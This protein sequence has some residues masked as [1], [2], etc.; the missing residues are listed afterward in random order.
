MANYQ[1]EITKFYQNILGRAPDPGGLKFYTDYAKG[2]GSLETIRSTLLTSPEAIARRHNQ[3][4]AS[5]PA[6]KPASSGSRNLGTRSQL[7]ALSSSFTEAAA[8]QAE[9]M[10]KFQEAQE[11]RMREFQQQTIAAQARAAAPQQTA[12]VLGA[13]AS[14][15]GLRRAGS[16]GKFSR[17]ELQIKSVNI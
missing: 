7:S 6:S 11:E 14:A 3:L 2:G 10:A 5:R 13:G 17:P 16:G 9:Q 1:N 4:Y 15:S 12:Q 8:K